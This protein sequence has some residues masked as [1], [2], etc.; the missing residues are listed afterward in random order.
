MDIK[1]LLNKIEGMNVNVK[2]NTVSK[3]SGIDIVEITGDRYFDFDIKDKTV[4]ISYILKTGEI[5][6]HWIDDNGDVIPI[7]I[8]TI[9]DGKKLPSLET[10]KQIA[11]ELSDVISL[12]KVKRKDERNVDSENKSII[13]IAKEKDPELVEMLRNKHEEDKERNKSIIEAF[14]RKYGEGGY[15][16]MIAFYENRL[17]EKHESVKDKIPYSSTYG[18]INNTDI[19]TGLPVE[20]ITVNST[21]MKTAIAKEKVEENNRQD[22]MALLPYTNSALRFD[23][24]DRA[25]GH[26]EGEE[27]DMMNEE[28]IENKPEYVFICGKPYAINRKATNVDLSEECDEDDFDD[29]L[30]EEEE[31]YYDENAEEMKVIAEK[32]KAKRLANATEVSEI[33]TINNNKGDVEIMENPFVEYEE[34]EKSIEEKR[35]SLERMYE[36]ESSTKIIECKVGDV[37]CELEEGVNCHLVDFN[38]FNS[39]LILNIGLTPIDS[40]IRADMDSFL[41]AEIE[42]LYEELGESVDGV[43]TPVEDL[44][45][46]RMSVRNILEDGLGA[47]YSFDDGDFR[48]SPL[49]L[50]GLTTLY[51]M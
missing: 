20:E 3:T 48:L 13:E 18:A 10:A 46:F 22:A 35:E 15:D 41:D 1:T 8:Q 5:V 37:V 28:I 32:E 25:N 16:Q 33:K 9:E 27:E 6:N 7:S 50:R 38:I 31:Y 43:T 36:E 17:N 21:K 12:G 19:E 30:Y 47:W 11:N 14:K 42:F 4:K 39:L 24:L 51:R 40:H 45:T 44:G 26:V 23:L 2:Q 49:E 29:D 34:M